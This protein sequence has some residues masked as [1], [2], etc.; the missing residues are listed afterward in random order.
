MITEHLTRLTT[1]DDEQ[2]ALWT[3]SD[4]SLDHNASNQQHIFLTHGTFSDKGVCMGI[5]SYL[6]S[7]G[8]ICYIMEWRGH[9]HSPA[10]K[11]AFKFET[12]ALFDYTAAFDYLFNDLKLD[13]LHTVTHSGGGLCLTMFLLQNESYINKISSATLF[14]CQAYG[15][16]L[17]PTSYAKVIS[18]KIFNRLFGVISAKKF[19]LGPVDE[20]YHTMLQWYDW[21]LHQNFKSSLIRQ[22]G[23]PRAM[24][25]SLNDRFD[26]R[27]HMPKITI[28]VYAISG[29]G[30]RFI[31]PSQG[32]RLL[33]DDFNHHRNIFREY[34][35]SG[36]DAEDYTHSRIIISRNASREIW[37]TVAAWIDQHTN[38]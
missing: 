35:L 8:H 25:D 14:A 17:N 37:P 2:I 24:T 26:Y 18:A 33:L 30:D 5:A 13:H 15:A 1:A 10:P 4:D 19:K 16:A 32:C 20:S 21:N 3:V 11:D 23:R 38:S 12:I 34:S 22:D 29:S 6:A 9:G 28:P 36:G 7:L 27:A 31:A